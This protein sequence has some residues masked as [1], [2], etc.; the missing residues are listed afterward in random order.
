MTD[1]GWEEEALC[2][3]CLELYD[4]PVMLDCGHNVCMACVR[5]VHRFDSGSPSAEDVGGSVTCPQCRGTTPLPA[6]GVDALKRNFALRNVV[7]RLKED[8]RQRQHPTCGN[9]E[10]PDA[11]FECEECNFALCRECRDGQH[12]KGGYKN[13][14]IHPLGSIARLKPRMCPQHNKELDLYDTRDGM[15]ICIY[16][17]QLGKH[18]HH[19]DAVVPLS[20]AVGKAQEQLAEAMERA[21]AKA[22]GLSGCATKLREFL[23]CIE[24]KLTTLEE[25]VR[26]KFGDLRSAL[27]E[28]EEA[29]LGELSRLRDTRVRTVSAQ[30]SRVADLQA[31]IGELVGGCRRVA[32]AVNQADLLRLRDRLLGRLQTVS[33]HALPEEPQASDTDITLDFGDDDVAQAV[34]RYGAVRVAARPGAAVQTFSFGP[35]RSA[36]VLPTPAPTPKGATRGKDGWKLSLGA[37]KRAVEESQS[38]TAKRRRKEG[39]TKFSLRI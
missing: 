10:A 12:S 2:C 15:L 16:C 19:L 36:P 13:H 20:D 17:L 6:A 9:C 28:R 18:K 30:A 5:N 8:K 21:T 3:V 35:P 33:E 14:T 4:D 7:D 37:A 22:K 24:G 11:E 38:S 23:P 26:T 27:R 25:E 31:H 1:V 32:G 39:E 29:M 34:A